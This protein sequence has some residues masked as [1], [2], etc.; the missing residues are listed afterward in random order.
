M[1]M[2]TWSNRI[3]SGFNLF[4]HNDNTFYLLFSYFKVVFLGFCSFWREIPSLVGC[5]HAFCWLV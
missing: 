2:I 5:F 4:L 1:S 3:V